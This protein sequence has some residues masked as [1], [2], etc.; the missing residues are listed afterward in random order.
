MSHLH[1]LF[2]HVEQQ[3]SIKIQFWSSVNRQ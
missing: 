1:L 3:A 2:V